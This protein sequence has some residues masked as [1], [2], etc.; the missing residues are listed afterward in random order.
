MVH[1]QGEWPTFD[2][3]GAVVTVKEA[4]ELLGLGPSTIR[5]LATRS[6]NPALQPAPK[7]RWRS[8]KAMEIIRKSVEHYH[9]HRMRDARWNNDLPKSE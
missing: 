6:K 2:P 8:K 5:C 3:K 4:G 1:K 9:A 7:E